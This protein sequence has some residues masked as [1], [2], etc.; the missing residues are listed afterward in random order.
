MSNGT[1]A[2]AFLRELL[3]EL[4]RHYGMSS[5]EFALAHRLGRLTDAMPAFDR[6]VWAQA[7]DAGAAVA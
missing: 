5:A 7:C 6:H 4:E 2:P 3:R 1:Y